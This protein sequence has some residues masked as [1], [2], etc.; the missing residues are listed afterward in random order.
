[1]Q[2]T[3]FLV[4]VLLSISR[5]ALAQELP[6]MR[7]ALIGKSPG[8]IINRIDTKTLMAA[9]QQDGLIMFCAVVDKTGQVTGSA[10]YLGT[11]DSKL[12][13]QEVDRALANGKMIPAIRNHEPVAV[14]FYGTVVFGIM[15]GK[16]RLRLF[17]NQ[18]AEEVKKESDFIAPQPCIGG[19]S[20]FSLHYPE[21]SSPV[22]VNAVV[23]LQLTVDAAGN[24]QSAKVIGESPP[25][26][27]FGD[28]ATDDFNS[29][30]FIPPFRDGKAVA[31]E[32]TL[33]IY[34]QPKG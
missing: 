3:S 25:L 7:P 14:L 26:L 28:A 8:A 5:V 20:K 10:T 4:F 29:A 27:G 12:L 23:N 31:A 17:A 34:Y 13:A 21:S 16:P 1:M 15:D 24:L 6:E 30:K 33:S 32:T 9:H 19:D 18:D 2:R 22:P 11:P